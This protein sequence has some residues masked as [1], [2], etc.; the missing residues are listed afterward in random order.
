[1]TKAFIVYFHPI[2]VQPNFVFK[3]MTMSLCLDTCQA[4]RQ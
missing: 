4:D 2:Q 1:M 3:V